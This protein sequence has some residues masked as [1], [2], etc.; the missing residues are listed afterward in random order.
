MKR[1]RDGKWNTTLSNA[2]IFNSRCTLR[3]CFI[4]ILSK[5][6]EPLC[7]NI[8]IGVQE[9]VCVC[10]RM[11]MCIECQWIASL[12]HFSTL[13]VLWLNI[14]LFCTFTHKHTRT[15]IL[16]EFHQCIDIFNTFILITRSAMDLHHANIIILFVIITNLFVNK[17]IVKKRLKTNWAT[18]AGRTTH[19]ICFSCVC[20]GVNV[21]VVMHAR[22]IVIET[23]L[24]DPVFLLFEHT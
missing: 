16:N 8:H 15:P 2:L 3:A 5:L 4:R 13:H 7:L 14:F 6:M 24:I 20:V 10:V 19:P 12:D 1:E 22:H 18:K 23:I 17:I 9:C 21:C 11:S